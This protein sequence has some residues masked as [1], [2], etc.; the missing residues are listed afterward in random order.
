MTGLGDCL[1]V[2]EVDFLIFNRPPEAFEKN[3]VK[4]AATAVHTDTDLLLFQST[5]KLTAGK[6]TALINVEDLRLRGL[7]GLFQGRHTE[8]S[9]QVSRD[10]SREHRA[11]V[12]VHN[13]HQIDESMEHADIGDIRAPYLIT[14]INSQIP[15]EV[16]VGLVGLI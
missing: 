4:D 11:A 13:G 3:I 9:I 12:P 1:V 7:Q 8:G 5:G 10:F 15:Q 6:L 2:M 16:G 14:M